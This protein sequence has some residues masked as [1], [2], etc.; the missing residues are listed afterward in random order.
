MPEAGSYLVSYSVNGAATTGDT[1]IAL[2]LNGVALPNETLTISGSG[3]STI[4][5][6]VLVNTTGESTLSIYNTSEDNLTVANAGV[7]VLRA[8]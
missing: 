1:S 6:T 3:N 5:K 4:S 7:T 2:Y 8:D